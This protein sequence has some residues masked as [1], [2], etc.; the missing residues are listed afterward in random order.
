M[1]GRR[2]PEQRVDLSS[3]DHNRFPVDY[4]KAI[5][6]FL[7]IENDTVK[8]EASGSVSDS[9]ASCKMDHFVGYQS[10]TVYTQS[11]MKTI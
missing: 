8:S 2:K 1:Y 10:Q 5:F 7:Y 4:S 3:I 11:Q 6:G 9:W